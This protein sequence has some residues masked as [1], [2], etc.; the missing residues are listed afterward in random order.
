MPRL[1][2]QHEIYR[3]IAGPLGHIEGV[4]VS[5]RANP[6]QPLL[7]YF[8][9]LP[10]ALPPIGK[11]RFRRPRA[12][13]DQYRYGTKASP[14][15]FTRGT[16]YCPQPRRFAN[17]DTE[18]WDE[19]CL[20]LNIYL[21]AGKKRPANGWPVFFY[22]HGGFLQWGTANEPPRA[23]APL[24][25]ETAFE[26]IIVSPSYRLNLFGFLSSK[27]LQAEAQTSGEHAGNMGF[28]DQRTAL[29]WT[30]K[31]IEYFGGNPGNITVG[32]YS[33]G[34]HSA[35]HQL[36]HE[37]YFVPDDQAIIK[38]T[39][40]W[41]N[42]PGVQP[43]TASDH[44]KQFDELLE[45]LKIPPSLSSEVKLERLRA[46]PI[47]QLVDIQ[48]KLKISEFRATSDESFVSK[49]LI[50]KINSG[51][52]AKRM[53]ARNI[54]LMN[55]ECKEEHNLYRSW[56]TP[57]NSYDAVR[58]RLIGDYPEDV[59]DKLMHHYCR[60]TKALPPARNDWPDLFGRIYA[61]MQVHH[62]ERGFHRALENGGLEFGKDVFRYRFDWRA[63]CVD[64]YFP[65]EWGVTHATDMAI[66]FW[67]LDYGDGLSDQDK[68]VLK[69]WNQGF[70]AFV[71]DEDPQWGTH[72][73]KD[74]K[75]LRSDGRTDI[76]ID[77]Q[78]QAGLDV[79][80]LVNG[81]NAA[82]VVGW[83]RSKL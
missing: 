59:V 43:R 64:S 56:R 23:I 53:K 9:G 12:L 27:E 69:T 16:A 29:E 66:W 17:L 30:A 55:G 20:Q 1:H 25:S 47:K 80:D 63:G 60:G 31:S 61:D 68:E 73:I 38:R 15:R 37:L 33:A 75:R 14:G 49:T 81:G 2:Y 44:Q 19:D 54:K 5:E 7:H 26:A 41:S 6:S 79:W 8:G 62:L 10:Y 52:F 83:I 21:P 72:G 13:P 78:W 11:H 76:W 48:E 45:A 34:A 82:G 36:A 70:A 71:K 39:I 24:M 67:G 57:A 74:M 18:L 42:S 28:W 50:A 77:E 3:F 46:V 35:F 65:P 4:T 40:C 58:T 22:I 51:D 32:G